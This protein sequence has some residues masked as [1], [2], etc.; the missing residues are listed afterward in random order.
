MM[1][2]MRTIID[3]PEN[4]LDELDSI[5]TRHEC[6]RA[7]I[8][9]EAIQSFLKKQPNKSNF[10]EAFGAWKERGLD[11]VDYQNEWRGEWESS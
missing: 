11:G 10:D 5:R 7:S 9:R 8:I 1:P 2:S 4:M 3:I 6:S